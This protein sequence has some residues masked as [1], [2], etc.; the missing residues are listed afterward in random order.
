MM[1]AHQQ[2]PLSLWPCL[3]AALLAFPWLQPHHHPPWSGFHEDAAMAVWMAIGGLLLVASVLRSGLFWDRFALALLGL[4]V[5][6]AMQSW[7]GLIASPAQAILFIF[8]LLGVATCYTIARSWHLISKHTLLDIVF[9][10]IAI[11]AIG[12]IAVSLHQ[13]LR[14]M[15][16]DF[17][18]T[19]GIWLMDIGDA[20]R[21]SGNV[22]QPNELATLISWGMLAGIWGYVRKQIG[23]PVLALYLAFLALGAAL[24]QSRIGLLEV[25]CITLGLAMYRRKFGGWTLSLLMT[26]ALALQIALFASLPIILDALLLDGEVRSLST[27]TQDAARLQIYSMVIEAIKMSPWWG[28]GASHQAQAQW[29][30]VDVAPHLNAYWM[31]SHNWIL[32]LFLWFGLPLGIVLTLALVW[33]AVTIVRTENEPHSLIVLFALGCFCLHATVELI[34]WVANFSLVAAVFAGVLSAN[35]NKKNLLTTGRGFNLILVSILS[36]GTVATI[37]DYVRLEE[38]FIHLLAEQLK[39]RTSISDPPNSWV[40]HH[41]ADS[42]RIGRIPVTQGLD[43]ETLDWM[44]NTGRAAPNTQTAYKLILNFA[45]HGEHERARIWMK[46]LNATSPKA[47]A[48]DYRRVWKIHQNTHPKELSGLDWPESPS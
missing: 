7:A 10:G 32:D 42:L 18:S 40:L 31:Q 44:E 11:A 19:A 13:W 38:N 43:K 1:N 6:V 15:P 29:A 2:R 41:L 35:A 33:W 8:H 48:H 26:G 28:Y 46:R 27:I 5:I 20:A 25:A 9:T 17:T 24:T 47:W 36:G 34:H 4:S 12:N 30:L 22:A 39:L 3:A 21:F 14:L 37:V 23:I 45:L 16:M